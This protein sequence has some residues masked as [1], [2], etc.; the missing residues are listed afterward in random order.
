[1]LV[2]PLAATPKPFFDPERPQP[3][4]FDEQWQEMPDVEPVRN[5]YRAGWELFLRH[6]AEDAPF[7]SPFL[8]GAKSVQL[9]E[10]CHQSNHERRWIDLPA[11]EV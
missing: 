3:M 9:A 2:Q 8:E 7:P 10:A 6:V 5:G 11:L 1:V 4:D